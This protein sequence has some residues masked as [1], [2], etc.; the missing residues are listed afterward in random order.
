MALHNDTYVKYS[1][2]PQAYEVVNTH[3]HEISGWTILSRPLHLR[4]PNLGGMN[5]DVQSELSTMAFN[6]G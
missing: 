1:M 3:D 4:V 6:N 5:G 2:S